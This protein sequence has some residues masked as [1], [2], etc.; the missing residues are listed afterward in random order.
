MTQRTH[1][2]HLNLVLLNRDRGRVDLDANP[3][4]LNLPLD[5][6]FDRAL[7]LAAQMPEAGFRPR[8]ADHDLVIQPSGDFAQPVFD[9]SRTLGDALDQL[10]G[11]EVELRVS[12]SSRQGRSARG[13]S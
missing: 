3:D 6:A 12:T 7:Q 9:L 2:R 4:L 8:S 10:Q 5:R 11:D 13:G 1:P